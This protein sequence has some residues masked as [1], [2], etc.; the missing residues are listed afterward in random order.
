MS[1]LYFNEEHDALRKLVRDFVQNEVN[2]HI[3][4]W[5][6]AGI[7]PAHKLF[8]QMGDLGLLG[9]DY[10]EKYGGSGMD[11]WYQAVFLEEIGRMPC[12]GIPTAI[13]VQTD[14]ATPALA[15]HGTEEQ[16]E[17][18][19]RPA[20]SGEAVFSIAVSEPDAG[21]DVAAIRTRAVADGDDYIINGSKMWITNG[22]QADYLTLLARTDDKYGSFRGM[23]LI[24]VPTDTPGFSVSR[25]LDK[26]GLRS[27]DTAILRFDDMRVPQANRIGA[28]GMGFRLQ[29]QQFQIER[30]AACLI[31]AAA[32]EEIIKLTVKYCRER[33]VFGKPLL[34]NQWIQFKLAELQTEIEALKHLNYFCVRKLVAGQDMTREA[35]MAKL[36]GGRLAREVADTCIQFHGGMGY[37]EEYPMARYFRDSRLMSIGGGADEVMMGIIAKYEGWEK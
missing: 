4:E 32:M 8:K 7:F 18:F 19:L 10:P 27:S 34:N 33:A 9:L 16:K 36:K 13:A 23:S 1:S 11:Y 22:T 30:L 37:V 26:L 24:I 12:S 17:K 14:M 15:D 35:S 6:E 28:E 3:D 21:S 20:I 31:S 5:E 25:K 29:M 2:P